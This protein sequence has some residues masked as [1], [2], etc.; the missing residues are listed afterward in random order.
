MYM[1]VWL[2]EFV[3]TVCMHDLSEALDLLELELHS[4]VIPWNWDSRLL[5]T[6][7]LVLGTETESSSKTVRIISPASTF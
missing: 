6:A 7:T 4:A 1:Y 2:C 5:W 3:S